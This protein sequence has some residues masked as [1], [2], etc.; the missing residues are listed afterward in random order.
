MGKEPICKTLRKHTLEAALS[1]LRASLGRWSVSQSFVGD[2]C[3]GALIG[4][5]PTRQSFRN[6]RKIATIRLNHRAN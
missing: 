1:S 6:A 4:A 2:E 5:E 3:R